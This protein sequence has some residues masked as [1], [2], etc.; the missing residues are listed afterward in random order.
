[1]VKETSALSRRDFLK[2]AGKTAAISSGLL[3]SG[4]ALP[5][6]SQTGA[7]ASDTKSASRAIDIHHHY[8]P[9]ELIDEVKRH[10]KTL[11]VEYFPPK[12]PKDNP[13]QIQ[14]PKGNRINPDPRIAA[15]THPLGVMTKCN[16]RS[17]TDAF[18]TARGGSEL[19]GSRGESW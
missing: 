3:I 13:F 11:G 17:A 9:P 19:D 2:L 4:C 8:L 14:F 18:H 16:K 12:D 7:A 6:T 15:V 10:G 5:S 1:M